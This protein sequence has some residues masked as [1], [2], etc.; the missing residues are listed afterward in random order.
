MDSNMI[1]SQHESAYD[2]KIVYQ[3]INAV[4]EGNVDAYAIIVDGYMKKIYNY[5]YRAVQNTSIAEELTQ[6]IF[7]QVYE[8]L[9][10][11]D[12]SRPFTPWL[13]R[14]ASNQTVSYLRKVAPEKRQVCL[15]DS[16][17]QVASIGDASS[18]LEGQM[19]TQVLLK[20]LSQV[21]D[22]YR[23]VLVLRYQYEYPYKEISEML[24]TPINTLKTWFRRGKEQLKTILEEETTEALLAVN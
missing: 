12:V 1:H 11:F 8:K 16:H 20:A 23:T 18:G 15:D 13:M 10:S 7:I 14:V 19:S 24:D 3:A 5:V 6:E 2:K 21:E 17:V 9:D 4:M 22:K